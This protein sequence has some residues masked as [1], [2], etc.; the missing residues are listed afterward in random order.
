MPKFN[1]FSK[2][3]PYRKSN[4]AAIVLW[5]LF[6]VYTVLIGLVLAAVEFSP[7]HLAFGAI[8]YFGSVMLLVKAHAWF[9]EKEGWKRLYEDLKKEKE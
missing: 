3:N 1:F 8:A 5:L 7:L 9:R 2:D 6:A 4:I